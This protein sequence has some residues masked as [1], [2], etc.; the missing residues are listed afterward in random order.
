M[1]IA[2]AW[3]YAGG[4]QDSIDHV[5]AAT[6]EALE[7]RHDLVYPSSQQRYATASVRLEA[8][9]RALQS[10]DLILGQ[11]DQEML[12]ARRQLGSPIPYVCFLLGTMSRGAPDLMMTYRLFNTHDTLVGNCSADVALARKFF[13]NALLDCVP[14]PVSEARFHPVSA[15]EKQRARQRLRLDPAD[16]MV[17][18]AG[19]ISLE[20]NLHSVLRVFTAVRACVPQ[21]RLVLAGTELNKPFFEFGVI[22]LGVMRMLRTAMRKL[23]LPAHAV[24]FAPHQREAEM[25]ELYNVADAVLNL[26]LHHDEN[27]GLAQVEAM[28]CGTPVVGTDWGGL[29]DTI[30]EDETGYKV[31]TRS[32]ESGVKIAWWEAVERL[33]GLLTDPAAHRRLR[34][35]CVE[36]CRAEYSPAKFREHLERMVI[37]AASGGEAEIHPLQLSDFARRFWMSCAPTWGDGHPAYKHGVSEFAAYAEMIAIFAGGAA[38][39]DAAEDLHPDT[40]LCLCAPVTRIGEAEL[41]ISDPIFPLRIAVPARHAAALAEMVEA[42]QRLAILSI[43]DLTGGNVVPDELMQALHWMLAAGLVMKVAQTRTPTCRSVDG[44][45]VNRPFVS[46]QL[47]SGSSDVVVVR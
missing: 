19:R 30:R 3:P 40:A 27:F 37:R 29:K 39:N 34:E 17:L 8:V 23:G 16:R 12:E 9:K 10:C 31:S 33:V 28:A 20:K 45:A 6:I 26:T 25:R 13:S 5:M 15:S 21:A 32:T 2:L 46:I 22:P 4:F 38:R 11:L 24:V 42:F 14:F 41:E 44:G 47:V 7:S 18:Y 36:V 1:K 35:R 43:R